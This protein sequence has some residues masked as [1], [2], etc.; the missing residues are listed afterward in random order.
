[1]RPASLKAMTGRRDSGMRFGSLPVN[2]Q[3]LSP[4]QAPTPVHAEL[5]GSDTSIALGITAHGNTPVLALCRQLID[6]GID[7]A[8]ALHAYRGDMLC[9]IVRSI[10]QGARLEVNSAGT[11]FTRYRE[12]RAA[13]PMRLNGGGAT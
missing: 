9:L 7:P 3:R 5:I 4:K 13:S 8:T 6:T 10:G 11:D 2:S 12:V 1:M